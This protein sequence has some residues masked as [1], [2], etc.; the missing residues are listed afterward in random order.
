MEDGFAVDP[1][2]GHSRQPVEFEYPG[3]VEDVR[4][5]LEPAAIPP[6]APIEQGLVIVSPAPLAELAQ[7]ACCGAGHHRREPRRIVS[8]QSGDVNASVRHIPAAFPNGFGQNV[9]QSGFPC[10]PIHGR[11]LSTQP[12]ADLGAGSG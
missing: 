6:V 3:T 8:G 12:I 4:G 9:V 11:H 2:V 7:R 5:S 1:G 10:C